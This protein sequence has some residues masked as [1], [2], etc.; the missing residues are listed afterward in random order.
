MEESKHLTRPPAVLGLV[1]G[2]AGA[3]DALAKDERI[4]LVTAT[5]STRMGKQVATTVAQR[6]GR[7]LLELGGNNGM[8]LAPSADIELAIRAIV[9]AA[10]GT[11]G[12][13]CT[14][15]RRLFVHRSKLETV[16]GR[17]IAIYS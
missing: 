3:G 9:F 10:A 7:C 13:R 15:L 11:A 14:T 6:L 2:D 5:G 17:L 1:T 8:I 16:M 12:Q 4:P